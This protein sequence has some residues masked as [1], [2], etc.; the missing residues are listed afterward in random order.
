MPEMDTRDEE[1]VRAYVRGLPLLQRGTAGGNT[2]CVEIQSGGETL[3]IDAGSG[4]RELGIELMKGPCGQGK[5]TLHLLITHPHWDHIQ[6]FPLFQPAFVPGNRIFIYGVHDLET[7]FEGQQRPLYWPV[8]LSYMQAAI[9]FVPIQ[10]GEEVTLGPVRVNSIFST[11]PGGSYSYRIEDQH[12]ILVHASD[13]EYKDLHQ[14]SL[15]PYIDF[16]RG[17]AALVFDAQYTL[18]EAWQ[19]IDWGHSSAMIGVDLARAASVKKLILFHHDPTYTDEDLQTIH[20]QVMDY[21]IQDPSSPICEVIVAYEGLSLDLAPLGAVDLQLTSD[22]E[23]AILSPS[24]TFDRYGVD[25]LGRQLARL[26]TEAPSPIIDLS[27]V[28]ILTTAGL[29]ALVRLHYQRRG[30]PIVLAGPSEGVRQVIELSG[31]QDFFALY[32]SVEAALAAVQAREALQLPGQ[33]IQERYFIEEKLGE[34][35]LGVV[36]RAI[37]TRT[38]RPVAVKIPS[39]A[40]SEETINRLMLQAPQVT[41]LEHRNIVRV[42]AWDRA[43]DHFIHVEEIVTERTLEEVLTAEQT[44]DGSPALSIDRAMAIAQDIARAL[45]YAHSHGVIH[46]N[47][48]PANVFVTEEGA[49]LSGFGLG[50]LELGRNLL[51]TPLLFLSAEYL[52]PEQI[53]GQVLDA[54]TDLYALGVIVYQMLANRPPFEGTDQAVMKDHLREQA[55]APRELNPQ[56]SRSLEHLVLKLLAKNPNDRYASA[57]QA[58]NIASS[59]MLGVEDVLTKPQSPLVGREEELAILENNWEKAQSGRG[60]LVLITG[61]LGIGKSHLAQQMATQSAAPVQLIGQGQEREGQPA[62][63]LFSQILRSYFATVPP[64]FLDEKTRKLCANLTHLVPEIRQMLPDLPEAAALEPEQEQLRLMSS[65][66]Q[67]VKRATQ[68]R[69]W[70][71]ILDDLQWADPNSLEL[72]RYL[73]RHLPSMRLLI[74]GIY[75]DVE[76]S[77]DHPL[78][79]TV[80]DLGSHPGY[81]QVA[82]KRLDQTD[83]TQLLRHIWQQ[84]IPAGLIEKIYQR[85]E[86][87]PFYVEE[88]AKSLED[89]GLVRLQEGRWHFP[90]EE[91]VRLPQSVREVVWRRIG[92]LSPGTQTLLSQAAVLGQSFKFDTLKEMSGLSEWQVLENLDMALERQLVQEVP[93]DTLLRFRHTE[94]QRVL[95]DDLSPLRRRMLHGQAA[96][97]LERLSLPEPER[98]AEELAY[99]FRSAGEY[100]RALAYSLPAGREAQAA[101]ANGT[102]MV[103]YQR[104]L[105]MLDQVAPDQAIAFEVTRLL[106]HQYLGEVLTLVGRYDEAMEHCTAA[107][108]LLERGTT[109]TRDQS[110][111]LAALS[112]QT[113]QVCERRGEYDLALAWLEKGLNYLDEKDPS[114]ELVR[115]YNLSGWVRRHQGL[116]EIAQNWIER[117]LSLAREAH[118][119]QVEA[120]SLRRLGAIA[121]YF[122]DY[123]KYWDYS[124]QAL[125]IYRRIGDRRGE[126]AVLNNLG[127][128]F[129]TRGDYEQA[130]A[131]QEAAIVI[132][133]DMGDRQAESVSLSNL[134]QIATLQGEYRAA[135]HYYE[136]SMDICRQIGDRRGEGRALNGLGVVLAGQGDYSQARDYFAHSLNIRREIGDLRGEG[137]TIHSLAVLEFCLGD[138][139]EA[140]DQFEQALLI[141]RDIGDRLGEILALSNVGWTLQRLGK[142]RAAHEHCQ[143]GVD[144]ALA[145][146]DQH[147]LGHAWIRLGHALLGLDRLDDAAEAYRQALEIREQM[148]ELHL[149]T[150]ARASLARVF[151]PQGKLT[152]AQELVEEVLKHLHSHSVDGMEDP[153]RLYLTSYRVLQAGEDPRAETVL[154]AAHDLLQERAAAIR[155]EATRQRF[156]Q[157][158]AA[159]RAIEQEYQRTRERNLSPPR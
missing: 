103:W 72:L 35:R 40:F 138:Y 90:S 140:N 29:Q 121:Y 14:A 74:L 89:D 63:Q 139:T 143:Q 75:R 159:N 17:A 15:Q 87:N 69:P 59:L 11:H 67:F 104:T 98:I 31:Y 5:G 135:K 93:G 142:H 120:D 156:L 38:K 101:Y 56:I 111:H 82:L 88:V 10:V 145:V 25:Q 23:A 54:R 102:A 13:A 114:I 115:I 21:Q 124:E 99:H 141:H 46:G 55:P 148:G 70:L 129:A 57:Q 155:E 50:Q 24:Y 36:L 147:L 92:H 32:P 134:G 44:Q 95:Y 22:G 71:L 27:Q 158:I 146:G 19:K 45:E 37:D 7:A 113:A 125:E 150:E 66:T 52:A 152:Q 3:I 49:K 41:A 47:L 86:G 34:S 76:L 12:S 107:L 106:A 151:L 112:Y 117:A 97:V 157:G 43:N 122:G 153:F 136:A 61:E 62:Y 8:T 123:P 28:E 65:L 51:D 9:E 84:D 100:E 2:P 48:K 133:E 68:D 131:Y 64:E 94:I 4:I 42:L 110:R 1:A 77:R 83:V 58:R 53:L 96:E 60:Q 30:A 6:G 116:Y 118:L 81:Q 109:L 149:A 39:P 128:V 132:W 119:P 85:T 130:R 144:V 127:I 20:S 137:E 33:L 80:R 79:E 73:A 78:L 18:R 126:G 16:F 108:A 105:E 26:D 91:E 154:I